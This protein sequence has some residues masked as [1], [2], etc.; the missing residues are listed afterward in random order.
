MGSEYCI[1]PDNPPYWRNLEAV[2]GKRERYHKH[3]VLYGYANRRLSDEDGLVIFLTPSQ[4]ER[5]HRDQ[6]YNLMARREA[7]RAYE[8]Q[9]GTREDFIERY[10]KNYL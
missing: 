9:K 1:M 6:Q 8:A 10:G 5:I 2:R 3:H 7:Q 4:H